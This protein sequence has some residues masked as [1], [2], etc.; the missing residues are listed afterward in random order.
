MLSE[1][2]NAF[3]FYENPWGKDTVNAVVWEKEPESD[4]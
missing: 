1:C 4:D 3:A 2:V